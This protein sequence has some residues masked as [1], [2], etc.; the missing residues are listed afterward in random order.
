VWAKKTSE[1]EPLMTCRKTIDG[2]KTRCVRI[3][4]DEFG[5]YLFTARAVPGMEVA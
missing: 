4:W 1:S 2:T 3:A 5:G